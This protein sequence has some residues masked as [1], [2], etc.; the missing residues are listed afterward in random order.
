[1][2][3]APPAYQEVQKETKNCNISTAGQTNLFVARARCAKL[4]L[5]RSTYR[6][7]AARRQPLRLADHALVTRQQDLT[8]A[9]GASYVSDDEDGAAALRLF[10]KLVR[11]ALH[12][13]RVLLDHP[14][15]AVAAATRYV[16]SALYA[17]LL[18]E[19]D[20]TEEAEERTCVGMLPLVCPP[21]PG[22]SHARAIAP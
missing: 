18:D 17:E 11:Q 19:C 14:Q 12:D 6:G 13:S 22:P 9:L 2:Q 16:E 7:M 10:D 21:P 15:L 4:R 5:I 1:M 20:R 8:D 3:M